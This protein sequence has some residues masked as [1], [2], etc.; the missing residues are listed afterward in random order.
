MTPERLREIGE[1]LYGRQ[2]VTPLAAELGVNRV[3]IQKWLAGKR[4]ISR[5]MERAIERLGSGVRIVPPS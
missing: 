5:H 1:A 4:L 3:T 2:W